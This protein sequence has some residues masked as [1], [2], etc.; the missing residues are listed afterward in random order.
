MY[1]SVAFMFPM[2]CAI[3]S[4]E[5][6]VGGQRPAGAFQG[7]GRGWEKARLCKLRSWTGVNTGAQCGIG[8]MLLTG[9]TATAAQHH[10]GCC[11]PWNFLISSTTGTAMYS[12]AIFQAWIFGSI[13]L[14]RCFIHNSS[15]EYCQSR[16]DKILMVVFCRWLSSVD[17]YTNIYFSEGETKCI[18]PKSQKLFFFQFFPAGV[19]QAETNEKDE[20]NIVH[21]AEC[22]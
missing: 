21:G 22:H 9:G 7:Q 11:V 5:K 2:W 3:N 10:C 16:V 14:D 17:C 8:N 20:D 19:W 12:T 15:L 1:I 4:P 18:R 13:F 6:V